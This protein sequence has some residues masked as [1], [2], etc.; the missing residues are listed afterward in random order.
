MKRE[1]LQSFLVEDKP[2]TK[3]MIDAIMAENG[4]DIQKVKAG[5]ADYEQLKQDL[6]QLRQEN[7]TLRE[8]DFAG[9]EQLAKDWEEKYN[10]AISSH[11]E[12]MEQME[13]DHQLQ[14]AVHNA[15]GR[16]LKA[17]TALLDVDH[18]KTSENQQQAILDA[19]EQLKL[20]SGYL[21]EMAQTPPPYA[22]GTG[23]QMGITKTIPGTLAGALRE[24]YERK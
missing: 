19:L 22:Q 8:Q 15:R 6:E 4:R 3:E 12:A 23:T 1:F 11:R 17:I 24:K 9:M 10:Q 13:F 7:E 5:F 21:F 18:L 16:N 14:L 20:D 2:L